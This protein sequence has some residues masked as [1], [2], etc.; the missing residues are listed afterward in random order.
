MHRRIV[1]IQGHPD[2]A[3]ERFC[4]ALGAA[5][6]DAAR[7]AGHQL[8]EVDIAALDLPPLR[9]RADWQSGAMPESVEAAQGDI[10]WADHVVL[11][12]PLWLG[13]VPAALKAF[14]EQVLRPGFAFEQAADG[15]VGKP[16]LHGR[17]ARVIVTMGMP[18]LFY[19]VYFR[20]HSLKSLRRN[21]LHFCGIRP[22]RSSIIGLV[23]SSARRRHA[24]LAR[25]AGFG[26]RGA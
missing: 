17:S 9:S 14:L 4:R 15:T 24:W 18:G 2:P 20:A 1:L 25:V 6:A 7:A 13:D 3:P 16:R 5:Y 12:Y 22:V 10:E 11:I 8:R 26:R 21:I 19:R 23:E